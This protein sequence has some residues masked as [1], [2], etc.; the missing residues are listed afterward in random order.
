MANV[1]GGRQHLHSVD[2]KGGE[3]GRKSA[4]PGV[5][6]PSLGRRLQS[7]QGHRRSQ[8]PPERPSLVDSRN[9]GE[10]LFCFPG[11]F[12]LRFPMAF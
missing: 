3:R 7:L 11:S 4:F 1:P 2:G 12:L 5:L 8:P 9:L 6:P 10:G